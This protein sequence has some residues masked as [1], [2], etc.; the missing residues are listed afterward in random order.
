MLNRVKSFKK[1]GKEYLKA[2]EN[3]FVACLLIIRFYSCL[4]TLF[5]SLYFN[6]L[7]ISCH[8]SLN[9]RLM[10]AFKQIFCYLTV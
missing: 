6:S 7:P 4:L 2:T 10:S 8:A 9:Y 3:T 5:L 1:T